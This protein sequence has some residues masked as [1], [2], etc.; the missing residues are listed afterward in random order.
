MD[1]DVRQPRRQGGVTMKRAQRRLSLW[2]LIAATGVALA[3]PAFGSELQPDTTAAANDGRFMRTIKSRGRL[4]HW[5]FVYLPAAYYS[6]ENGF[7]AGGSL[8]RHFHINGDSIAPATMAVKGRVTTKVRGKVE[9]T[10]DKGWG[11]Q[12]HASRTKI[13]YTNLARRFYG[14]GPN[15]QSDA[16]EVYR[17]EHIL[18]YIEY[19]HRFTRAFRLGLR[20]EGEHARVLEVEE[21]GLLATDSIPG[22]STEGIVGWGL[23]AD[24]NTTDRRYSPMHGSHHQAYV[25]SFV[26]NG[27]LDSDFAIYHV[28]L[29]KYL[30]LG[31]GHVLALQG[32]V[33]GV[34]DGD[35]PFW[36]LAALG[37]R[38]HTRGYRG[39]RY[40]DRLLVATQAEYRLPV[41]WRFGLVG[42]AGL[43]SVG[44]RFSELELKDARPTVGGGIR[45]RLGDDDEVRGRFDAAF[46]QRSVRLY[47]EIDEAF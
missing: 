10:F 40:L 35:P 2:L 18:G 7:G 31:H 33:Y 24:W 45:F 16:E 25:M 38:A 13:S 37:G 4:S 6:T 42:F 14:I 12:R 39:G 30:S 47:F 46:G 36:K 34:A 9:L 43:A 20:A 19:F 27:K 26:G 3:T 28:D 15:T 17:A 44:P 8:L 11:E 23:L 41:A 5:G 22:A 32:F 1:V 29:R 21:D